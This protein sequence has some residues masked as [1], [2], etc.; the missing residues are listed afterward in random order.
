MIHQAPGSLVGF[1]NALAYTVL[2]IPSLIF[3]V[4]MWQQGSIQACPQG[5]SPWR[6]AGLLMAPS[7][8]LSLAGFLAL[9]VENAVLNMALVAGGAVY[10]LA[11]FPLS[12]A[13]LRG[14]AEQKN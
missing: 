12:Y 14:E 10:W 13:L 5:N 1:A 2:G 6:A 9:F 3:G 8:I 4:L 7:G 11:L